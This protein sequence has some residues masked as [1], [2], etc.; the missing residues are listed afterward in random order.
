MG[1]RGFASIS[2]QMV[3]N[4]CAEFVPLGIA[5][6]TAIRL[7]AAIGKYG[8][9]HIGTTAKISVISLMRTSNEI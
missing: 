6:V 5:N 9:Q 1:G 2:M 7:E 3:G 4:S 8:Y